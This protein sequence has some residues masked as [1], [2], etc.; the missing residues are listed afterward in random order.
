MDDEALARPQMGLCLRIEEGEHEL[1]KQEVY[2][3]EESRRCFGFS[4]KDEVGMVKRD[5]TTNISFGRGISYSPTIP[6]KE[7]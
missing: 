4:E 5:Q 7:F 6:E 3:N 1:K 2:P